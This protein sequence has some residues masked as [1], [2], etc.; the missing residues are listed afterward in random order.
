MPDEE[1]MVEVGDL[2]P[3]GHEVNCKQRISQ[4]VLKQ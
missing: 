4:K 2:R 1:D 3:W